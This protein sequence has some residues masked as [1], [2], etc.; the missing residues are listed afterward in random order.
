MPPLPK[1][2]DRPRF[3]ANVAALANVT[4]IRTGDLVQTSGYT[5]A[6]DKGGD[7]LRYSSTGRSSLTAADGLYHNGPGADDYF[8]SLTQKG[9]VLHSA[10]WGVVCDGPTSNAGDDGT[11]NTDALTA[12]GQYMASDD[13]THWHL[14]IDPGTTST[15]DFAYNRWMWGV[16]SYDLYGHNVWMRCTQESGADVIRYPLVTGPKAFVTGY[17]SGGNFASTMDGYLLETVA[18]SSTT[19][20]LSTSSD[21]S[22][23][24]VGDRVIVHGFEQQG[25]GWPPN[26]RH[27]DWAV[28]TDVSSG[29]L[30]LDRPLSHSYKSTWPDHITSLG[31]SFGAARVSNLDNDTYAWP[32]LARLHDLVLNK[33]PGDSTGIVYIAAQRVELNNVKSDGVMV[34]QFHEHISYR[35]CEIADSDLDKVVTHCSIR[36]SVI[37]SGGLTA[38]TGIE[39]LVVE[40]NEIN[41]KVSVCPREAI[42]RRNT[43]RADGEQ[44]PV[45]WRKLTTTTRF[46]FHDNHVIDDDADAIFSEQT[47]STLT[48]KA[49]GSNNEIEVDGASDSTIQIIGVG[50]YIYNTSGFGGRVTDIDHDGTDYVLSGDWSTTPSGTLSFF[51]L[52]EGDIKGN[53]HAQ[54][55]P[56]RHVN[57]LVYKDPAEQVATFRYRTSGT[58]NGLSGA[59]GMMPRTVYG[60]L[61]SFR[62]IVHRPYTGASSNPRWSLY[63]GG[64]KLVA[65][66]DATGEYYLDRN[67]FRFKGETPITFPAP[68]DSTYDFGA[69]QIYNTAG[70]SAL[71]GD[72]EDMPD[73]ECVFE[74][75]EP[76]DDL[77]DETLETVTAASPTLLPF[78]VTYLDSSSNA[79]N[80]TLGSAYKPGEIKTI[81]M[82]NASN[83]STVSVT[84]HETSDPEV[85]TFDAVDECLVLIWMGTEWATLKATATT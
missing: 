37:G 34:P 14:H 24:A 16:A 45:E 81:V 71:G 27:F 11:D 52:I 75:V 39:R 64:N 78:G 47:P 44:W 15:C 72:R 29:V 60:K 2:S 31:N 59:T 42:F 76:G 85:F 8:E 69:V 9:P 3:V 67:G 13:S 1:V 36:D 32:K 33:G 23:F 49:A 40:D 58:I 28:V 19:V 5:T 79:V 38:A 73:W 48:V 12:I 65:D 7:T 10:V 20:T 25:A 82:T 17:D 83:S 53:R 84:N 63:R 6:G 41:G 66:L 4:G 55:P 80:A 46:V 43:I 26:M 56:T 30:T 74:V 77:L 61:K 50:T 35:N 54:A 62:M 21:D 22:N 18:A 70:A 57:G 68:I 51:G